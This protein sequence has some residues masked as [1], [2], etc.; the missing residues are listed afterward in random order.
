[1]VQGENLESQTFEHERLFS[2]EGSFGTKTKV[3][4][5]EEKARRTDGLR[6]QQSKPCVVNRHRL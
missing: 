1:M 6:N 3:D 4:D 2:K 5:L